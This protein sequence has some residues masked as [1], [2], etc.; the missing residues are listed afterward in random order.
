MVPGTGLGTEQAFNKYLFN[1]GSAYSLLTYLLMVQK[2]KS[3]GYCVPVLRG[4]V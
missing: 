3:V 4:P 2:G 1:G